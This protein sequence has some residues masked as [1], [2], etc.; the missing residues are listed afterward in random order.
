MQLYYLI[1]H[2]KTNVCLQLIESR[3]SH[4]NKIKLIINSVKLN[5]GSYA[6]RKILRLN[7]VYTC[8][9]ARV[10]VKRCHTALRELAARCRLKVKGSKVATVQIRHERNNLSINGFANSS[11]TIVSVTRTTF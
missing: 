11:S 7:T 4:L 6:M 3:K 2:N 9:R 5:C 8:T 1:N 10:S